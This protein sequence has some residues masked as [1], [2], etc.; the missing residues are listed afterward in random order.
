M[1]HFLRLGS[2]HFTERRRRA[3][4]LRVAQLDRFENRSTVTPIGLAALG[5]GAFPAAGL[6]GSMQTGG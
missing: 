1:A 4:A 5:V 3:L 6:V 2:G